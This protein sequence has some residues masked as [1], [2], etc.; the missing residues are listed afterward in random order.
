MICW[1]FSHNPHTHGKS[2]HNNIH[3]DDLPWQWSKYSSGWTKCAGMPS[4]SGSPVTSVS[5]KRPKGFEEQ[6]LEEDK[7]AQTQHRLIERDW[8]YYIYIQFI[9]TNTTQTDRER[10]RVLYIYPTIFSRWPFK[11]TVHPPHNKYAK[12]TTKLPF[13]GWLKFFNWIELN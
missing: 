13:V 10:L 3:T 9:C 6:L 1:A 12:T 4:T 2:H 8:E 7:Y 5:T 11:Q